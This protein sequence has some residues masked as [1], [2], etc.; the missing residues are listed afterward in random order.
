MNLSKETTSI[1]D[2]L[3]LSPSIE[4]EEDGLPNIVEKQRNRNNRLLHSVD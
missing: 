2:P 1:N 4:N 3:F